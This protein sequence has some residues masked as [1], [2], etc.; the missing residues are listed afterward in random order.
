MQSVDYAFKQVLA[1][2]LSASLIMSTAPPPTRA[3]TENSHAASV[4]LHLPH[5]PRQGNTNTPTVN[6]AS[7]AI[8]PVLGSSLGGRG[9]VTE[10]SEK[11]TVVPAI[12]SDPTKL[13]TQ[14]IEAESIAKPSFIGSAK[15]QG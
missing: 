10:H 8:S 6:S 11:E 7:L 15:I 9:V 1:V 5:L 3:G 12:A 13:R 14:N 2:L 4:L